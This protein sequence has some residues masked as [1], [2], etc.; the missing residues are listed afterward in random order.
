VFQSKPIALQLDNLSPEVGPGGLVVLST[1]TGKIVLEKELD[2]PSHGG[3]AIQDEF[4]IFGTGYNRY[5]RT[6][7]LYVMCVQPFGPDN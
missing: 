7:S 5:N 6:G 3:F 1:D 2:A 4:L